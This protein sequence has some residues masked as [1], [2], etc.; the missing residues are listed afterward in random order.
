[1]GRE[2][3][4]GPSPR[5]L[6]ET[7]HA[8]A[9]ELLERGNR[10]YATPLAETEHFC[11][12]HDSPPRPR[13][14]AM[15]APVVAAAAALVG[16]GIS[17]LP[18]ML[19]APAGTAGRKAPAATSSA[20]VPPRAPGGPSLPVPVDIRLTAGSRKL[21]DGSVVNL[22]PGGAARLQETRSV[23]QIS[24]D[25]G[26][27]AL[28]VEPRSAGAGFEVHAGAYRFRVLGTTFSVTRA[29]DEVQL[30]VQEGRVAVFAQNEQLATIVTGNE[31]SSVQ[32]T[33]PPP[34]IETAAAR[35]VQE[36][37]QP[38]AAAPAPDC[39]ALA[40]S[41]QPR[42]AESCYLE[43]SSGSDLGSEMALFEVARLRR[44]VLGDPAGALEALKQYRQRFPAG[45]LRREVDVAYVVLLTR[46]GRHSEALT[47]SARLLD[48]PGG[49]ERGFELRL[50]RGNIYRKSLGNPAEAAREYAKAEQFPGATSEATYFRGLC[51]EQ[52]GDTAGAVAAYR[53][54]LEKSPAGKR[55]GDVR[56]SLER[57]SP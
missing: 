27:V 16:L 44:D 41:G 32:R 37:R 18:N 56:R 57:L 12:T 3:P 9:A 24:L 22:L 14:G 47:E 25:R 39:R 48:A 15:F 28:D 2:P 31:W 21:R 11:R 1:M 33:S 43:Q 29:G 23:T 8:D 52:L 53:D 6:V 30:R 7:D 17:T 46:V 42:K 26:V 45:S 20:P 4:V 13:R 38:E 50:L 54:Y 40:R 51:L 55:A 10:E 19:S 35:S 36:V 5:R 49:T 34:K